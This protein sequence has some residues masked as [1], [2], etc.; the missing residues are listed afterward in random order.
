MGKLTSDELEEYLLLLEGIMRDEQRADI[1]KFARAISVPGTPSPA[2]SSDIAKRIANP[3]WE[4]A[5]DEQIELY[6]ADNLAPAKHH[7]LILRTI[8]SV[9]SGAL[10]APD[11]GPIDGVMFFL[12][13]GSSK[14]TYCSMVAPAHL[15]GNRPKTNVI[16]VSYAQELSDRFSRRVRSIVSS[17]EYG[18]IFPEARL[19]EG[20]TGVRAWSMTNGSEYRSVGVGAGIAGF[21][22]DW[23]WCDDILANREEAESATIRDKVYNAL[24]DDLFTRLKPRGKIGIVMTRWHQ[25]DP[26]GRLLGDGWN[27]QSGHWKGADG[28]NWYVVCC[29]LIA[30]RDDD[31]L[32]RKPGELLW[33]E[34]FQQRNADRLQ[35]DKSPTGMR[36]W[37]SLY[38]QRPAPNEGTIL[39]REYWRPW[40]RLVQDGNQWVNTK[41][42]PECEFLFL[43][44]DTATEAGEEND[45][46]ACTMWGVFNHS[47]SAGKGRE[48]DQRNLIMLGAWREKIAAVD[49]IKRVEAHVKR[50]SPDMIL[51]EKRASGAQLIQELKRRRWP[52]KAWLPKGPP[53]TRGKVPRAHAISYLLESGSVWYYPIHSSQAQTTPDDVID[54]SAAFPNGTYIDLVDTVTQALAW[55]RD[56]YFLKIATDELSD[57]EEEDR[58]ERNYLDQS[59]SRRLYARKP[60]SGAGVGDDD[61]G[62]AA[63]KSKSRRLYGGR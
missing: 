26:A 55:A 35:N 22:A 5:P 39:L 49:L 1:C 13:P 45:Y 37:A 29:P 41:A 42:P 59:R 52:V 11:G 44:Y 60:A 50:F 2:E 46:S 4:P 25:S 33:P 34:W 10:R 20:N 51:I 47:T 43:S 21:R 53:G 31:P 56:K 61:D 62:P 6:Y 19:Q 32:G 12:P 7:D 36:A 58:T 57:E 9:D 30:E 24:N 8:Q 27:G 54:E 15:M 16:A 3:L 23:L 14:S 63:S 28:R 48:V 17:K 38:Q 18:A 40:G